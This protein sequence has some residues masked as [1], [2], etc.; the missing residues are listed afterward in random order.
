MRVT[1]P[2]LRVSV[3]ADL[4]L[5]SL[6]SFQS[7]LLLLIITHFPRVYSVATCDLCSAVPRMRCT[8]W[9]PRRLFLDVRR[10]CH[11]HAINNS[12]PRFAI[13]V[14]R[15]HSTAKKQDLQIIKGVP[16]RFHA[17]PRK[18]LT[19]SDTTQAACFQALQT[20]DMG[21][22]EIE[23]AQAMLGITPTQPGSAVGDGVVLVCVD[24]E[25]YEMAQ[26]KITEIGISVL[27][28]RTIRDVCKDHS[29]Q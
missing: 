8:T 16:R 1:P 24:C 23:A 3:V 6:S 26:H 18:S 9:R 7:Y 10:T 15:H 5:P 14:D 25:A 28:T 27:D 13:Q 20:V 19:Q 21:R 11:H 29:L 2:L 22:A 17:V 4:P 12:H